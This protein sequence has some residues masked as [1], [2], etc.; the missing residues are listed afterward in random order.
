MQAG[1]DALKAY[2]RPFVPNEKTFVTYESALFNFYRKVY[3][4]N[5]QWTIIMET[6]TSPDNVDFLMEKINE[7]IPNDQCKRKLLSALGKIS[8]CGKYIDAIKPISRLIQTAYTTRDIKPEREEQR[9][10][11]EDLMKIHKHWMEEFNIKN[12]STKKKIRSATNA[13]ITGLMTGVYDKC[14]P[15]RLQ[16]YYEM[17]LHEQDDSKN[18]FTDGYT[19]MKINAH[20][21]SSKIHGGHLYESDVPQ[22][23]VPVIHFLA[24]GDHP[25]RSHLLMTKGL[26][27]Y[28][29][30]TLSPVLHRLLGLSVNALRVFHLTDKYA[31]V[32][33]DMKETAEQMGHS[34]GVA[35]NCYVKLN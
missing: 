8:G 5:P 6:L 25:K 32:V 9:K 19:K 24:T 22:E 23:L 30:Q 33:T 12:Q 21:N 7:H 1:R 11:K 18:Y 3:A 16:D 31:D 15:R 35:A 13:I 26:K 10:S 28:N 20:K 14:P 34:V 4:P 17:L 27:P 2:L 29:A